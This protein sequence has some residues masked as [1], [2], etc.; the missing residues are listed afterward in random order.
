MA[1]ALR[2]G[3]LQGLADAR[4]IY[5][6]CAEMLVG[7]RFAHLDAIMHTRPPVKRVRLAGAWDN[8]ASLL[9]SPCSCRQLLQ[10]RLLCLA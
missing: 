2:T 9:V 4:H 1:R 8:V 10:L 3:C 7:R 6:A 5:Q